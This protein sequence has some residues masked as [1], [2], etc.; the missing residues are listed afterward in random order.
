MPP[1]TILSKFEQSSM[2]EACKLHVLIYMLQVGK[3]FQFQ[4][5]DFRVILIVINGVV[6]R[7]FLGV[8]FF[9]LLSV[10][11]RTFKQVRSKILSY[12]LLLYFVFSG[13]F[14]LNFS[15]FF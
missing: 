7:F 3:D 6:Q 10:A 8:I 9:F 1:C 15:N 14:L 11:E 12:T 4:F 2:S 5:S 13:D